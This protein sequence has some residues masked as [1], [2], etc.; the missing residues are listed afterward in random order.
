[1]HPAETVDQADGLMSG[2]ELE[3]LGVDDETA[4][5]AGPVH[6]EAG[7]NEAELVLVELEDDV[8][9]YWREGA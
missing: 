7:E 1:M 9:V 5:D 3:S 8:V 4:V 2:G 6:D